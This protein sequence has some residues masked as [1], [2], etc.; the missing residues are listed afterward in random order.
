MDPVIPSL[1]I[2][3]EHITGCFTLRMF[4]TVLLIKT[5]NQKQPKCASLRHSSATKNNVFKEQLR[6]WR[7]QNFIQSKIPI[8]C[9]TF[10]LY[11]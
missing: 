11:G 5:I 7:V 2:Y 1:G 3:P 6:S 9:K 8:F 4:V 10:T